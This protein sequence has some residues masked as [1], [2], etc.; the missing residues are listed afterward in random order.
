MYHSWAMVFVE[1]RRPSRATQAPLRNKLTREIHRMSMAFA[2][3]YIE[4]YLAD[5]NLEFKSKFVL[6]F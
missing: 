3:T 6:R 1:R 2:I 5:V 4:V